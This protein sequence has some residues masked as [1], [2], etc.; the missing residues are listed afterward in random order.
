MSEADKLPMKNLKL[1]RN[2]EPRK[3]SRLFGVYDLVVDAEDNVFIVIARYGKDGKTVYRLAA[4][5]G[6]EVF[7]GE[8][9]LFDNKDSRRVTRIVWSKA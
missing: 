1:H 4:F 3:L 9:D 7:E 2:G 8:I 5:P 6:V